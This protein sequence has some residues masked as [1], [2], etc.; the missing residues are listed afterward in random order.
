MNEAQSNSQTPDL[1]FFTWS[2]VFF[3][4]R[5]FESVDSFL[6]WQITQ[7]FNEE[8]NSFQMKLQVIFCKTILPD[9][10]RHAVRPFFLLFPI[11]R[12]ALQRRWWGV[13]VKRKRRKWSVG[14]RGLFSNWADTFELKPKHFLARAKQQQKMSMRCNFK[15]ACRRWPWRRRVKMKRK[16]RYRSVWVRWNFPGVTINI[17]VRRTLPYTQKAEPQTCTT[18][19][20]TSLSLLPVKAAW[21]EERR[22]E[23]CEGEAVEEGLRL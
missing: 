8:K 20:L 16:R 17:C 5:G 4:K 21:L 3:C 23:E 10:C 18:A 2:D 22:G 7:G 13:E 12:G 1:S 11:Q 6:L 19:R 14:I 9:T 15:R